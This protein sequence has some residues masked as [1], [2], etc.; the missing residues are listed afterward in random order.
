MIGGSGNDL[1]KFLGEQLG[2]DTVQEAANVDTDTLDFNGLAGS[3]NV[4]LAATTQQIV[5][6][7]HLRLTIS[8]NTGIENASGGVSSTGFTATAA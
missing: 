5:N 4:N 6:S 7:T 3:A 8:S 2:A 1:Y